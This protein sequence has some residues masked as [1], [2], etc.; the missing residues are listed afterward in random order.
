[1]GSVLITRNDSIVYSRSIVQDKTG[2]IWFGTRGDIIIYDV[3]TFTTLTDE[4]DKTFRNV[5][6]PSRTL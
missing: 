4:D 1:M 5:E 6:R 3:K 2:K